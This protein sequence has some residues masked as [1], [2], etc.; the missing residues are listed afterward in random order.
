MKIEIRDQ[1]VGR[2]GSKR[3]RRVGKGWAKLGQAR[4]ET[5]NDQGQLFLGGGSR[6]HRRDEVMRLLAKPEQWPPF[7]SSCLF[8]DSSTGHPVRG[9]IL[10][11]LSHG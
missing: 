11:L 2:I 9:A 5:L 6:R 3:R 4:G 7:R 1:I 10:I 8:Q